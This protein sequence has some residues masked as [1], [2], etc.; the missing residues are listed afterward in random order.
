MIVGTFLM[1]QSAFP[2]TIAVKIH[3]NVRMDFVYRTNGF[4]V[5]FMHSK[6]C[7]DDAKG[8]FIDFRWRK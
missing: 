2:S 4:A 8:K 1:R 6:I 5:S 7:R 3:L